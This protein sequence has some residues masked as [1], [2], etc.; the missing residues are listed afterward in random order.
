MHICYVHSAADLSSSALRLC[1]VF[2]GNATL[3]CF[4]EFHK[5]IVHGDTKAARITKYQQWRS[6]KVELG[7][8][9]S[10]KRLL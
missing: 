7:L 1:S 5:L 6:Q 3:T 2:R 4:V 9:I 10:I 8:G